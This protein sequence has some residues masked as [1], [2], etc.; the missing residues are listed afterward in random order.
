MTAGENAHLLSEICVYVLPRESVVKGLKPS[1]HVIL[2]GAE[3]SSVRW[4]VNYVSMPLPF[5]AL[6]SL[7]SDKSSWLSVDLPGSSNDSW[8]P[9]SN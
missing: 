4:K 6:S 2:R 7:E 3:G 5:T 8:H 9:R 1:S